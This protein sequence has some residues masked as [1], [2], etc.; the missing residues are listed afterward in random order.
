MAVVLDSDVVIGFLDR[1]DALHHSADAAVRELARGQRMVASVV[2]YAEVLTGAR[3]GHHS[4]DD[5]A[6]FFRGLLSAVL[7]IDVAVAD[8]AA[9]LRSR[10]KS[11]RMPDAL[12]LATAETD[13]DVDLIVTGDQ[14][15]TKVSGLKVK[16]RLLR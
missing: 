15:L 10:F 4:E 7:P 5:V 11:L 13:P 6:G 14:Q 16:V 12:I 1:Q 9:D 2:T 3:L 8:A